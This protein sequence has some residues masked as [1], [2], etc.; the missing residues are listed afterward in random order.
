MSVKVT[1]NGRSSLPVLQDKFE[2]VYLKYD[3]YENGT[4]RTTAILVNDGLVHVGISK[5]SNRTYNFSR[6]KSRSMA[7]GRAEHA[8]N[9]FYGIESVRESKE[10]RREELSFSIQTSSQDEIEGVITSLTGITFDK[11]ETITNS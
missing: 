7:L 11:P 5:F 3:R 8:A 6:T 10:K 9:I 4:A 2:K 1:S